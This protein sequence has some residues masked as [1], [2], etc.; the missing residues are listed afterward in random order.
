MLSLFTSRTLFGRILKIDKNV[1]K[2]VSNKIL[3][4]KKSTAREFI[5]KCVKYKIRARLLYK[6]EIKQKFLHYNFS[7]FREEI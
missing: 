1:E 6:T 3:L 7:K 2:I 4:Q 5:K